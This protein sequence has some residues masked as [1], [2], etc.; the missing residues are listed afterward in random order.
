MLIVWDNWSDHVCRQLSDFLVQ[1]S[2]TD[3]TINVGPKSVKAH[4]I[5]LSIFSPFFK[6]IIFELI[7]YY[8]FVW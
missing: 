7:F 6:V 8:H 1:A 2:L 3:V 4:Q 5:I